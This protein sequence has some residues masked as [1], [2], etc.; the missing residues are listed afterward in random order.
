LPADSYGKV[1]MTVDL[2]RLAGA[3]AECARKAADRHQI[4]VAE[5]HEIEEHLAVTELLCHIWRADDPAHLISADLVR[6]FAHSGNYVTGAYL[7]GQLAG[8]SIA[9]F[10]ADHLHSHIT[11][12]DP[13]T[14]GRGV[15]FALKQ[16]Q[17]W[18]ALSRGI[19]EIRWTFDPLVRRNAY[20]NIQ[21]LGAAAAAYLPEF[22]GPLIDGINAGDESDRLYMIWDLASPRAVAASYGSTAELATAAAAA[23]V[24][25]DRVGDRP[26][27][28]GRQP[29]GTSALVAV[30]P[31]IDAL[32]Q[33]DPALA[34]AWRRAL[35][36]TLT[37][38]LADGY[39]IVG[40]RRDGYY[41]LEK[42]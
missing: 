26:A 40:M 18:W 24:L 31:N 37:G 9:F 21:K 17:R 29:D 19:D 30:P 35:R 7:E 39:R 32:R 11:G 14:Q 12:V 1:V 13:A 25:L 2:G 8:A 41:L 28:T 33:R 23:S 42:S 20:F 22:Y 4:R 27:N 5:L 34:N 36:A 3:A 38:A 10:G 16:H 15:G 6:A